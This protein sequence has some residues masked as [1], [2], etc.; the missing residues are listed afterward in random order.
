MEKTK[1]ARGFELIE[2]EDRYGLPCSL[3]ESSLATEAAIWFGVTDVVP[4]IMARDAIRLGLPSNG[5]TVGWV[6]YSIPEEVSL[7]S[8][9]HLTQEQVKMLLPHLIKFVESGSI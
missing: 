2:F 7:S 8:R 3:Q 6:P 9:M 5:E 1:T 4:K